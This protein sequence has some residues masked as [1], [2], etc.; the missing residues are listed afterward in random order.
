MKSSMKSIKSVKNPNEKEIR[1]MLN[2]CK[3]CRKC[4]ENCH[5]DPPYLALNVYR[6]PA[7]DFAFFSRST[8]VATI[9][10]LVDK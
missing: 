8:R 10:C 9:I 2:E 1:K 5:Y 6:A 7:G 4:V 3:M